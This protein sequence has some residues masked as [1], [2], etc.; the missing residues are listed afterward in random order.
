M[1]EPGN[2]DTA[3]TGPPAAGGEPPSGGPS[4]SAPPGLSEFAGRVLDQ[5][6]LTAWLPAAMLVGNAAVLLQLRAEP[7]SGFTDAIVALTDKPLGVLIVLLFALVLSALVTQAMEFSAIRLL[8]GYWGHSWAANVVATWCV[9]RHCRRRKR[10]LEKGRAVEL[11][12]LSVARERMLAMPAADP[13]LVAAVEARARN[14]DTSTFPPEAL[15]D[16]Q[17]VDWREDAPPALLRR[18]DAV[19]DQFVRYPDNSRVLPTRLGN[20][21]RS[22]EDALIDVDPPLR[23][24]IMRNLHRIP[25]LLL[26]EHDQYRNRLDMYCM[27][28]FVCTVLA[29]AAPVLLVPARPDPAFGIGATVA[30]LLLTVAGYRAAVASGR[31]YGSALLAI[32]RGLSGP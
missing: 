4:A 28:V 26:Q 32:N 6:S 8:E 27:F 19:D 12:A 14:L 13:V 22:A 31:G 15:A 18:M 25:G 24:Y 30:Y 11:A 23:G 10:L 20:T 5:L 7:E 16:A 3:Q 1:H 29:V 17:T 21:I 2:G 9:R